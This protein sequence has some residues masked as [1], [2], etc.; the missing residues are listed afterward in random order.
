MDGWM[1]GI[2]WSNWAFT[3]PRRGSPSMAVSWSSQ[4]E[5][6]PGQ[7]RVPLGWGFRIKGANS[8]TEVKSQTGSSEHPGETNWGGGGVSWDSELSFLSRA[9][10]TASFSKWGNFYVKGKQEGPL[11]ER[12][13]FSLFSTHNLPTLGMFCGVFHITVREVAHPQTSEDTLK[14]THLDLNWGGATPLPESTSQWA[15]KAHNG[16]SM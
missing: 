14:Q 3:T 6:C 10:L 11:L 15:L 16:L 8:K 2:T 4:K 9:E 5:A 7:N 1:A 13:H 12:V